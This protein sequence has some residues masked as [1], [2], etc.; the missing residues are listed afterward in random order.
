MLGETKKHTRLTYNLLAVLLIIMA[1]ASWILNI[2]WLRLIMTFLGVP[3]LH[4]VAFVFICNFS[5]TYADK[6]AK[7]KK[8]VVFSF[9]TY[10]LGYLLLPDAGDRGP[11]Y[12][13]FGLI[14]SDT[15]AHIFISLSSASFIANIILLILQI[16]ERNRIKKEI[17][18]S[19]PYPPENI[20][21]A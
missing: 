7:L 6:S 18:K 3:L 11:M 8:Y 9:V 19:F 20:G 13:L 15:A 16:A 14:R 12:M 21:P 5:L 17:S 4:A 10:L 1:G 2:G